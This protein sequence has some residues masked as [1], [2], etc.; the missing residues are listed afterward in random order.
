MC[1]EVVHRFAGHIAQAQG[2]GLVVHFRWSQTHEDD[3]RRAVQTGLG[4]GPA[5]AT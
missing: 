1:A 3:A 4:V 5:W 2:D